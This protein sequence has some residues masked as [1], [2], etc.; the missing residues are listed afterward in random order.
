MP[1]VTSGFL[2]L[3]EETEPAREVALLDRLD[4]ASLSCLSRRIRWCLTV[5]NSSFSRHSL[6]CSCRCSLWEEAAEEPTEEP[7][8]CRVDAVSKLRACSEGLRAFWGTLR[9]KLAGEAGSMG[10]FGVGEC[11][12]ASSGF[13][14][15]IS[16][17]KSVGASWGSDMTP[18]ASGGIIRLITSYSLPAPPL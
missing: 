11:T 7:S 5:S 18:V 1:W 3:L 2:D 9:R 15:E 10:A 4:P 6:S 13:L 17:G 8:Q 16:R 12:F 14:G